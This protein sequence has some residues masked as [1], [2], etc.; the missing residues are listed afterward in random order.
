MGGVGEKEYMAKNN[1]IP[2]T[3]WYLYL[4]KELKVHE[5][6]QF[7][8]GQRE[9]HGRDSMRGARIPREEHSSL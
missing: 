3:V 4:I 5:R 9:L 1:N 8:E 6:R 2:V 7:P